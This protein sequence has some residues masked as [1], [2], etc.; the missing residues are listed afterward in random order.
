[1]IDQEQTVDLL[2]PG[3]SNAYLIPPTSW[4]GSPRML[5]LS[6]LSHHSSKPHYLSI[7]G[8]AGS[9]LLP[10]LSGVVA[11][12]VSVLLR[13]ADFSWQWFLL[14]QSMRPR[15][16]TSV[17]VARGPSCS[18]ACGIF[19]DQGSNPCLLHWPVDSLPLRHQGSPQ[20]PLKL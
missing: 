3:I 8:C 12:G 18:T 5:L 4:P 13:R 17:A 20:T 16:Q 10:G 2:L 6:L 15:D 19:S 9:S 14:F 7:F 11:S 1:M